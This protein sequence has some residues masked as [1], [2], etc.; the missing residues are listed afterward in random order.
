MTD[1]TNQIGFHAMPNHPALTHSYCGYML[2]TLQ[3]LSEGLT[4]DQ[5][6]KITLNGTEQK[7]RPMGDRTLMIIP[8]FRQ[9]AQRVIL[10]LKSSEAPQAPLPF[11][12]VN[13]KVQ[14][15]DLSMGLGKANNRYTQGGH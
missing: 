7:W 15:P 12:Q 10:H 13:P 2:V 4:T 1:S 11:S 3:G 8:S 9:E 6:D 14:S 5:V